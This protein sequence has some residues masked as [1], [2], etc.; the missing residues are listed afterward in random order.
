MSR[1]GM[2]KKLTI[3]W[4]KRTFKS[5][6]QI[7]Q[8]G[9]DRPGLSD[10]EY[11][12]M[13]R[14]GEV[15]FLMERDGVWPTTVSTERSRFCA[16]LREVLC[17][18]PQEA[19]DKVEEDVRFLFDDPSLKMLAVNAPPPPS[20]EFNGR[21]AIDTIVF[22]RAS[23]RLTPEALIGLI[24]QQIAHSFVCGKNCREDGILAETKAREW[25]FGAELNRLKNEQKRLYRGEPE[26]IPTAGK[27]A[28]RLNVSRA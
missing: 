6:E 8:N 19:F 21:K 2:A 24:A 3:K 22:F 16:A 18:L 14:Y 23:M 27:P 12:Q 10:E 15:M 17:R 7:W 26:F 13:G 11:T 9:H 4:T 20:Q 5:L 25:K 1:W 28:A